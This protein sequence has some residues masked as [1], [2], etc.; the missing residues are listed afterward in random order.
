MATQRCFCGCHCSPA[1]FSSR[2]GIIRPSDGSSFIRESGTG[3]RHNFFPHVL[4][5]LSCNA[6][7]KKKEPYPTASFYSLS[8]SNNINTDFKKFI[9]LNN[10]IF[11]CHYVPLTLP[12]QCC[13][14]ALDITVVL[15]KCFAGINL[16][17][18]EMPSCACA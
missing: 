11:T 10:H 15:L 3:K 16:L 9:F 1:S 13:T 12:S 14:F 4:E 7:A 8:F 5:N 2:V 6:A 18:S 17:S